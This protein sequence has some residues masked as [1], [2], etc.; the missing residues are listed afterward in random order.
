[1]DSK[2]KYFIINLLRKGT[3]KW[4]PRGEAKKRAKVQNGTYKNGNPKYG[5]Q[6]NICKATYASG[7]VQVDH[8]E[9]VIGPEG[10]TTWDDYIHRMFCPVD[11]FQVVCSECHDKKSAKEVQARK[12]YRK[13]KK[14]VDKHKK[15]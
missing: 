10:F 12:K 4:I 9:P 14:K 6:C 5:Y 7:D 15:V 8:I 2:F 3:F 1:M 13:K 11:N